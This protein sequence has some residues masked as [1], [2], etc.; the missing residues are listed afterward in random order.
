MSDHF[1]DQLNPSEVKR[2]AKK[3]MRKISDFFI[4]IFACTTEV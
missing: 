4:G 3:K 2:V 1:F